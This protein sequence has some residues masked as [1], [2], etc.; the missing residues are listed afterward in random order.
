LL[1]K[2]LT[3]EISKEDFLA[4]ALVMEYFVRLEN[5]RERNSNKV[6]KRGGRG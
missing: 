5:G 1:S 2:Y 3:K 6:E 4:R